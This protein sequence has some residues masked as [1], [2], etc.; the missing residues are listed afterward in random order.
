MKNN[1][2]FLHCTAIAAAMLAFTACSNDG[3]LSGETQVPE[4][5]IPVAKGH[6][7]AIT[8][9]IGGGVNTRMESSETGSGIKLDWQIGDK[10]YM[11]TSADGAN[12]D[13]VYYTFKANALAEGNTSKATFLCDDFSFP[14][15]T[16]KVKFIY[17]S[18]N[19]AAKA[20]LDKNVQTLGEQ[21]G[22]I[23]DV[24][25][26]IYMETADLD[27]TT[28]ED[29]KNLAATLAHSNAVMKVVIAK[30]DIQW[31]D[32]GY[33]PA[34]ITMKLQSNVKLA[35]T[36]EN[37]ITI[38]N[39]AAWDENSQIIANVVVCM[40][41]EGMGTGDRWIF[42]TK[43]GLGNSLVKATASAKLLAGGKRYNAPVNFATGDYFPLLS[44]FFV[45]FAGDGTLDETTK[46]I[47]T[48]AYGASGWSFE[49]APLNLSAY[50]Y[51]VI[52]TTVGAG[53]GTQLRLIDDGGFWGGAQSQTNIETAKAI[54]DLNNQDAVKD[55]AG[56]LT[57]LERKIDKANIRVACFWSFGGEDNK[58][59][60][61][62]LYLTTT[63]PDTPSG[64]GNTEVEVPGIDDSGEDAF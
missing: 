44:S 38:N 62:K 43:D 59:V 13:E 25:K 60:I 50:N 21:S 39:T 30:S 41:G 33:A 64:D 16:T 55:E 51:L 57:P 47:I 48:G 31:G 32:A 46:T 53:K 37:T 35:G 3:I 28:E 6:P 61:S 8:A 40:T 52:E 2:S 22:K 58:L 14:E 24:A 23:E 54:F 42:S 15:G 63:E 29:V 56:V 9:S 19:V 20:D 49:N 7:L 4:T 1:K 5:V 27:A 18:T 34:Q 36:T 26:H 10:L 17:T 45:N 11:L 12:W